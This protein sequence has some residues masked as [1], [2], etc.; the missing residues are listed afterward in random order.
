[1]RSVAAADHPGAGEEQD[2][3]GLGRPTRLVAV[4]SRRVA[5]TYLIS[6]RAASVVSLVMSRVKSAC[7]LAICAIHVDVGALGGALLEVGERAHGLL[8]GVEEALPELA[9]RCEDLLVERADALDRLVGLLLGIT[10]PG[11]HGGR[12]SSPR[13]RGSSRPGA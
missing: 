5:G 13:T 1:M 6:L 9:A 10:L 4:P 11:G 8:V 7:A 12:S 2:R 3:R